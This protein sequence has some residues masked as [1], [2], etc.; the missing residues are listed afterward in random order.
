MRGP[1][2]CVGYLDPPTTRTR[3]P[4]TA[5]SA[6]ATS[7][8]S[9]PTAGSTIVGRIKDVIIRG[10]ENITTAEVE[11]VL[12]AHPD[13]RQAVAVGYP[14]ALMGERVAAFVAAERRASTS[15]RARAWF[16][17]AGVA[18]FKTPGARRRRRPAAPAADG[19]ARPR[20]A[21][22][23]RSSQGEVSTPIIL[24]PLMTALGFSVPGFQW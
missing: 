23:C 9:T 18:R 2:V 22:P 24:K 3:S 12:E 1:E 20:R 8:R 4:P 17:G 10:G 6:P 14:D 15:T 13:V 7:R 16:A 19:Q 11:A 21:T 5:G